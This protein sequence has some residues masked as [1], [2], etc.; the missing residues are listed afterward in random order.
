MRSTSI[1]TT[2]AALAVAV[3]ATGWTAPAGSQALPAPQAQRLDA[4]GTDYAYYRGRGWR[5]NRGAIVAGAVGL[6]LLG[7]AIAASQPAYG[8]A[9]PVYAEPYGYGYG[10]GYGYGYGPAEPIY[11][12]PVVAYPRYRRPYAELYRGAPDPARGG[13]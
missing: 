12:A 6:G 13:R 7:A 9:E 5:G 11:E 3:M 10:R 8:Y 2:A 1:K 4:A